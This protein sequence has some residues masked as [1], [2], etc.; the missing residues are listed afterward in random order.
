MTEITHPLLNLDAGYENQ[1]CNF[2]TGRMPGDSDAI[3]D[4]DVRV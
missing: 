2:L 1:S 4:I 3:A